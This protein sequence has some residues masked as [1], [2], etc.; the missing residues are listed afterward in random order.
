[1]RHTL[2]APAVEHLRRLHAE[3][4]GA[5]AM[6]QAAQA[7]REVARMK[8][9]AASR[10]LTKALAPAASA[11]SIDLGAGILITE[12]GEHDDD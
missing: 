1:M 2:S 3:L 8:L 10:E 11:F 5:E 4:Q 6:V 9:E 7:R 12:E